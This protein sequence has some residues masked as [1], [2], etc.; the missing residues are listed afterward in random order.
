MFINN[1]RLRH[2][3]NLLLFKLLCFILGFAGGFFFSKIK[4]SG[5]IVQL[6]QEPTE[7]NIQAN[8]DHPRDRH[9]SPFQ[10]QVKSNYQ[11]NGA[12]ILLDFSDLPLPYPH[13]QIKSQTKIPI[14]TSNFFK[15]PGQIRSTNLDPLFPTNMAYITLWTITLFGVGFGIKNIFHE[16]KR[17]PPKN[18]SETETSYKNP[19]TGFPPDEKNP[20][21]KKL[22]SNLVINY[23]YDCEFLSKTF[24]IETPSGKLIGEFGISLVKVTDICTTGPL[25]A[26]EIW[27][28]NFS[29]IQP[30]SMVLIPEYA[31]VNQVIRSNIASNSKQM[32]IKNGMIYQLDCNQITTTVRILD[33][34]HHQFYPDVSF[35]LKHAFFEFSIWEKS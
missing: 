15:D 12:P 10:S 26:F 24:L 1:V 18:Q 8:T 23:Q 31:F 32:I 3:D 30:Q 6:E 13:Q 19:T 4:L 33:V 35:G 11:L 7:V 16:I 9:A 17:L 25:I 20:K 22:L 5:R 2:S 21:Q 27:L 14:L 28:H 34:V 29:Q